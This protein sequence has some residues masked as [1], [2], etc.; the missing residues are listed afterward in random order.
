[1]ILR[2]SYLHNGISY[3]SKMTSLYESGPWFS[4]NM[5]TSSNENIFHVTGPLWGESTGDWWIPLTKAS[6]VELSC[7][8]WTVPQQTAE[9]TIEMPGT[10]L[11]SLW[12]HCNEYMV[13]LIC[14]MMIPSGHNFAH[15]TIEELSWHL[16]MLQ[17]FLTKKYE[18]VMRLNRMFL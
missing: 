2:W 10:P 17:T 7:F 13:L 15:V 12:H 8:L 9:Q 11:P 4:T 6:D 14:K 16:M 5:M 1:M 18:L 3:A